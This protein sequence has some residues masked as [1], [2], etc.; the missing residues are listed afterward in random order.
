LRILSG[1]VVPILFPLSEVVARAEYV[2]VVK[3]ST[4]DCTGDY[5]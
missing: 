2:H 5:S 4:T 1:A 3:S